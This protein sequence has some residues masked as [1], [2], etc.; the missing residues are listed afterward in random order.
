M[1]SCWYI[2]Q[3]NGCRGSCQG[4]L[5]LGGSCPG[6]VAWCSQIYSIFF[7]FCLDTFRSL[8]Q[9]SCYVLN[10]LVEA[11]TSAMLRGYD[12]IGKSA[13]IQEEIFRRKHDVS[14]SNVL[15]IIANEFLTSDSLWHRLNEVFEWKHSTFYQPLGAKKLICIID[16]LHM[17]TVRY[18]MM[19]RGVE[20]IN[21]C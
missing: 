2:W 14:N 9:G 4:V 20:F 19:Q 17:C 12:G 6:D 21:S 13:I 11:S 18:W 8:F 7:S 15:K 16:D 1:I 5:F 10:S 3:N